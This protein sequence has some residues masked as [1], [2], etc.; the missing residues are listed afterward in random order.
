MGRLLVDLEEAP[1]N[2]VSLTD[3]ERINA[4]IQFIQCT[5][6]EQAYR[7]R[8]LQ[9]IEELVKEICPDAKLE[10]YGSMRTKT[11][12]H[13]SDIDINM[14]QPKVGEI[15]KRRIVLSIR[16]HLSAGAE[17]H[18]TAR[19]PRIFFRDKSGLS[20]DIT[21]DNASAISSAN[22][23]NEYADNHPVFRKLFMLLKHWLFERR[24]DHVYIGGLG[25]S[26]L[27][28]MIIGW[29]EMQYHKKNI[30]A[31]QIPLRELLQQFFDFWGN[32]WA[33]DVFVLR[34]L[35]GQLVTKQ[36]KGW[37]VDARPELLSIEDPIDRTNDVAKQSFQIKMIRAAFVASAI[38]LGTDKW[39]NAFAITFD[40]VNMHRDFRE[41]L[42]EQ[43]AIV[44]YGNSSDEENIQDEENENDTANKNVDS[45]DVDVDVA[46]AV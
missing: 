40:E 46:T 23:Q 11:V 22:L 1:W 4:F 28:Y 41:V 2:N 24:L 15:Q 26:A 21:F 27:S 9:R 37:T 25:S 38:E 32:K 45:M 16:K 13:S 17:F 5:P 10:F 7:E 29:L 36:S 3:D 42:H 31:E 20:V 12:I 34:P 14:F 33:Y 8:L 19:V 18:A 6:D 30:S 44:D 39:A 35:T 43:K